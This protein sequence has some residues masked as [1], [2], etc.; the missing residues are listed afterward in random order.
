MRKQAIRAATALPLVCC[1]GF[2]G[3]IHAEPASGRPLSANCKQAWATSESRSM[4]VPKILCREEDVYVDAL[5]RFMRETETAPPPVNAAGA[6]PAPVPVSAPA[7]VPARRPKPKFP[8]RSQGER[9]RTTKPEK[10]AREKSSKTHGASKNHSTARHHAHGK[11]FPKYKEAAAGRRQRAARARRAEA[12]RQQLQRERAA[13]FAAALR[14]LHI[15]T[16]LGKLTPKQRREVRRIFESLLESKVTIAFLNAVMHA[17]GGGPLVVVGGLR[18]KDADCRQRIGKLKFTGHPKEQ[19]LPNR[20]FLKTPKYGLSTAAGSWQIVYYRN[21]RSLRQ[22]LGLEDFR[23]GRQ[24]LAALELVR[25]SAVRG[26]QVGEGLVALLRG[27]LDEA[28]RKGTDPWA[29]S[30]YSRWGGAKV[31]RLLQNAR[32]EL[33]KL[34]NQE[35]AQKQQKRFGVKPAPETL[36]CLCGDR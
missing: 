9:H 32:E 29:S 20:C 26:G 19:G 31:T 30:P 2:T 15:G 7:R 8:R 21:W 23:E 17:E 14:D 1:I 34:R 25:S 36:A 3:A 12:V 35:Y 4:T 24:A 33:A 5:D 18:G 10:T 16:D 6:A 27:N 11:N 22:L 13:A 28:I